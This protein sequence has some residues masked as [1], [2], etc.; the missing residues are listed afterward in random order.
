MPIEKNSYL[1][2]DVKTNF[3]FKSLKWH[4]IFT[5]ILTTIELW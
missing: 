4:E 3:S 2:F 1:L 5:Q